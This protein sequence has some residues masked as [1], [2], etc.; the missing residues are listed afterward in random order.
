MNPESDEKEKIR[1]FEDFF[2]IG[3]QIAAGMEFLARMGH[4]HRDLATRNCLLS[5]RTRVPLRW[6]S[7]EALEE[8]RYTTASDVY[9]FGVTLWEL[10]TF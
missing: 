8:S 9:A 6:L 10:Y 3:G 7:K 4:V 1:N 5:S 2:R